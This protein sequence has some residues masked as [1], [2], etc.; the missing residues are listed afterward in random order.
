[1]Y[2]HVFISRTEKILELNTFCVVCFYWFIPQT[3]TSFSLFLPCMQAWRHCDHVDD[4]DDESKKKMECWSSRK[5]MKVG[6]YN[7]VDEMEFFSCWIV[8]DTRIKVVSKEIEGH[9][10]LVGYVH[11]EWY[12]CTAYPHTG[13]SHQQSTHS[14]RY[15]LTHTRAKCIKVKQQQYP[16]RRNKPRALIPIHSTRNMM[17]TQRY[18]SK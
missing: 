4:D 11:S 9:N 10:F 17:H 3:N 15:W 2:I 12:S 18:G 1:M 6:K 7:K 5:L 16:S 14:F 13:S 8:W